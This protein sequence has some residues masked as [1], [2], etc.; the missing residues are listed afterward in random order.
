MRSMENVKV[1]EFGSPGDENPK[2]RPQVADKIDAIRKQRTKHETLREELKNLINFH[3]LEN[4]SNTKD[5]ILADYLLGCLSAC[6]T[7]ISQRKIFA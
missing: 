7:A 2:A 5:I 6:D 3:S 1:H 4:A